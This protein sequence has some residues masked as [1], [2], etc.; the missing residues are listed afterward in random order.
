MNVILAEGIIFLMLGLPVHLPI[1]AIIA[2]KK[3]VKIIASPSP[4]LYF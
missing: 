4:P 3:R 2:T 1:I